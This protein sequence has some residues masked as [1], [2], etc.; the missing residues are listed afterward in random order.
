MNDK[1]RKRLIRFIHG[2]FYIWEC[3][4][5]FN[6]SAVCTLMGLTIIGICALIQTVGFGTAPD[7]AV[8]IGK[9]AFYFGIGGAYGKSKPVEGD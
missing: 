4:P 9:A 1:Y 3:N 8:E 7:Y 2:A 6:L 5:V